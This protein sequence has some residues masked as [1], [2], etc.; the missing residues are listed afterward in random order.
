L[1]G[2]YSFFLKINHLDNLDLRKKF[3][4]TLDSEVQS[5]ERIFKPNKQPFRRFRMSKSTKSSQTSRKPLPPPTMKKAPPKGII[6]KL[7]TKRLEDRIAPGMVG[8]GIVDPGAADYQDSS[9]DSNSGVQDQALQ[10]NID[11][12]ATGTGEL[13]DGGQYIDSQSS[14]DAMSYSETDH[15]SG[16]PYHNESLNQDL[17]GFNNGYDS[18]SVPVNDVQAWS[19]PDWVTAQADG[20]VHVQPPAGVTVDNGIANFPL[21]VANDELPIPEEITL[22][23]DGSAN[24]SLPEGASFNTETNVLTMS[25]DHFDPQDIP[26]DFASYQSPDGNWNIQLPQDGVQYDAASNSLNLSNDVLNDIAPNNIEIND[27]GSVSVTLPEGTTVAADGSWTMPAGSEQFMDSPPPAELTSLDFAQ[28]QADG[29]MSFQLPQGVQMDDGIATFPNE[30][31]EQLP[32]PDSMTIQADG[33][34]DIQ[35]PEGTQW[36]AEAGTLTLPAGELKAEDIP[37]SIEYTVSPEGAYSLTLPE[38]MSYENG[39]VHCN[40]FWANEIAPAPVLI[41]ADGS[42]SVELPPGTDFDSQSQFTIPAEQTDFLTYANPDYVHDA[43]F[44]EPQ[45]D[46]SYQITPPIGAEVVDGQIYFSADMVAEHLPVPEGVELHADGTMDVQVPEGTVYSAETNALTFPVGSIQASDVPPGIDFT[47]SASGVIVAQLP[48]GIAY[49]EGVCHIDNYWTNQFA[50]DSVE[51]HNDGSISVSLPSDTNYSTDGSFTVPPQSADFIQTPEPTYLMQGPDWVGG[52]AD[53]SVT[54]QPPTDIAI[55]AESGV[56][57]MSADQ[58][59]EHFDNQ[60]HPDFTLNAD[61]TSNVQAPQGTTYNPEVG[62]MT[63]P[64]DAVNLNE[65]PPQIGAYVAPDGNICVPL[66]EGMSFN[67]DTGSVHLDNYWTNE[68]APQNVEIHADGKVEVTLPSNTQYHSDGSFTVPA[69]QAD[70]I[71]TPEPSFVADGP[72]WVNLEANGSVTLAP[73]AGIQVHADSGTMTM[74]TSAVIEHFENEIP[75]DVTL[76]PDGTMEAKVPEGTQWNAD[77]GALTFPAGS[78]SLSEIPEGIQASVGDQG[79]V[80]VVLPQGIEYSNGVCHFDNYWTN[81]IAPEPVHLNES[82]QVSVTLP[83]NTQ[84]HADGSFSLPPSSADFLQNPEPAFVA[85]GPEW[86]DM[87]SNGSVTFAPP[88]GVLSVDPATNMVSLSVDAIQEHFEAQIPHDMTLNTDGTMQVQV[89][90]GTNY[91]ASSNSLTFPAGSVNANEVPNGIST[92]VNADGSLTMKLPEGIEYTNGVC[93]FDNYWTNEMLPS[94]ME[95]SPEGQMYVQM[96]SDTYYHAD[97]SFSVPQ[98]STDFMQQPE[99]PYVAGGPDWAVSHP[100][101][102]IAFQ[103][104]MME[105]FQMDPQAGTVS[106]HVDMMYEHFD[107]NVPDDVTFNADGTMDVKLPEGT[108]FNNGVLTFSAEAVNINEIPQELAPQMQGDGSITVKLP[109][110][111]SYDAASGSVHC[112]NSWTNTLTPEHMDVKTDGNIV[113]SM[114][115]GTQY[116]PQGV[117]IPADQ[118]YFAAPDYQQSMGE[119]QPMPAPGTPGYQAPAA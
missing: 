117:V 26:K 1:T 108:Q 36:N 43:S 66:Q 68:L 58:V 91:E 119:P 49:N 104:P 64:A 99:P 96:P 24:V 100:D 59:I 16:D 29:S 78:V 71:S 57:T 28:T 33:S 63:M 18:A 15:A 47:V 27:N 93:H 94:H 32:I 82:G 107:H 4:K 22:Q 7:K 45:F 40:N 6:R 92:S 97:G 11:S 41:N 85:Q 103:P 31:T 56:I 25:A 89:P 8:G 118:A 17:G 81:E 73:P 84:Y 20:S 61:G 110:G 23:A 42:L 95:M 88:E 74:S 114:P 60:V 87:G 51:I 37:P 77:A 35:V 55:N 75:S 30:M 83:S 70:F 12:S 86:V 113:M 10:T 54:F 98:G 13:Q 39:V 80:T 101:G 111:I 112:D 14:P 48:E 34:L 90:E 2:I 50:P 115:A 67:T 69:L 76:N 38:G 106:M 52:N 5:T 62:I 53:G 109:E 46:G 9:Q 19:E 72:E 116:Y 44:A 21:T 102:S 3:L 105:Q 79:Q 65:I